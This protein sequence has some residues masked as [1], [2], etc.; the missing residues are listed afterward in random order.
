MKK[1]LLAEGI[2]AEK[3]TLDYAGF[4]TFDSVVRSKKIFGQDT[5]TIITQDFHCYRALFISDFYGMHAVAFA[6]GGIPE[7]HSYWT[8]FRENLARCK[9]VIDLY[10][11][12]K[13]PRFLVE[14]IKIGEVE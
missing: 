8:Y 13:K 14:E 12:R 1:A 9:A 7:G 6:T 4:R 11:L 3:I 10:I 5:L 2:P